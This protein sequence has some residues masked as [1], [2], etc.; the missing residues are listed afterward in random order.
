MLGEG[1]IGHAK[2][3]A[4]VLGNQFDGLAV[5]HRI[6]LGQVSHRLDQLPLAIDVTRIGSSFAS[7][8]P[9]LGKNRNREN[10]GHISKQSS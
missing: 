10:L 7:L 5:S 8:A 2:A 9:Y 4:H 3:R 6:R 1:R